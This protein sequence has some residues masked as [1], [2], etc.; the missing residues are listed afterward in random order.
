MFEFH[1]ALSRNQIPLLYRLADFIG[2]KVDMTYLPL[3]Q[4]FAIRGSNK[5]K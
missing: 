5:R 3:G 1:S 4:S 2:G